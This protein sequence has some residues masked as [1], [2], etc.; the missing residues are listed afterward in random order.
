MTEPGDAAP[1]AAPERVF[2]VVVDS[3]PEMR[4]AL[5]YA[6]LRAR[7]VGGRLVLLH[8]VE[9]TVRQHW[10][11]LES[12]M[13]E[14][15]LEEAEELMHGIVTEAATITGHPPTIHIR[16]GEAR[17]ELLKLIEEDPSISILVLAAGVGDTGPGPLVTNLSAK[18]ISRLRVP[19]TIVPG[20]LTDDEIDALS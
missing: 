6:A 19:V 13:R 18:H 17:D 10:M 8:V 15:K 4:V 14:E 1:P 7:H 12:L 3:S 9:A 5:R 20:G 2:L 16:E 11:A